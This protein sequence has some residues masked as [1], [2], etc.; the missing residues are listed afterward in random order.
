M[1]DILTE[2]YYSL[3]S[4][5]KSYNTAKTYIERICKFIDFTYG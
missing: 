3:I 5:G 4:S 2:Y 1:P